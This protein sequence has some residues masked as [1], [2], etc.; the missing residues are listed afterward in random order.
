[1]RQVLAV[2]DRVTDLTL[3][4]M[5]VG[6]SG[7]G[8]ELIAR[9]IH[10]NGPRRRAR[11]VG[12]NCAA[13]PEALAESEFFGHVRGA[14]TG[15]TRDHAGLFE[16]AHQGTLFLDEVGE[17]PPDL[18]KKFLRVLEEGAVR[19]V[20]GKE[21]IPV[22]VRVVSATNRDPRRLLEAGQFREDLYYRLAGVVIEV[23]PLRDRKE[24][25]LPL[26]LHFL[27]EAAAPGPLPRMEPGVL[28]L[29][30][31]YDW[32]GNV[33]ELRNEV[34]RLVA[35]AGGGPVEPGMVS[36]HVVAYRPTDGAGDRPASMREQ[37]EDLERRMLRAALVR[38]GWNKT[39][40]AKELGLSRLGLRKKLERY[41][42]DAEER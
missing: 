11:I 3:P 21:A 20:G 29:L 40:A 18:Q 28:D 24:D 16:Q 1:M 30:Q 6:E 26:A 23:P 19:R 9:A 4:V 8:K 12:E 41:G 34:R 15:A 14:F 33:R 42:L 37:V 13:V 5:I 31:A 22:D 39:R 25:V 7:T 2:V 38:H 10:F 27:G 35:F 32:P 36:P 17:M